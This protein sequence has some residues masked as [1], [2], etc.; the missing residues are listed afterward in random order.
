MACF[1]AKRWAVMA[2][3]TSASRVSNSGTNDV[4]VILGDGTGGL[5]QA[6]RFA[7]GTQ[8]L[9]VVV[10]DLNNDA[11]PDLA[12]VNFV[13]NNLSILLGNI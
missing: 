2:A 9:A 7:V 4:S 11:I 10:A 12:V 5:E 1:A 3:R 6:T 13:S 8:P